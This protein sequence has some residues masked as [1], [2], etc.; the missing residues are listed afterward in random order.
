VTSDLTEEAIVA[1]LL[2][3]GLAGPH[4]SHARESNVANAGR[5]V[6]GDLDYT[7]GMPDVVSATAEVAL[8]A[9]AAV[10]GAP[11]PGAPYIDPRATIGR[12]REAAAR[13]AAACAAGARIIVA[14]GHPTGLLV[15]HQRLVRTI[16]AA[17]GTVIRPLEE[18]A[19]FREGGATRVLKYFG[20]VAALTD[21]ANVLHAHMPTA[22]EAILDAEVPD[23]VFADHGFAG[24]AV[25]R[26]IPTIAVMDT[27]DPALAVAWARGADLLIVPMDDNRSPDSY[28]VIAE[29][30]A[31]GVLGEALEP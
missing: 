11:E 19:V 12:V 5:L 15:H 24:A 14:T 2:E 4:R 17:G 18:Q 27:N 21:G 22:M 9:V 25:A 28:D 20:G 31:Q 23:L 8:A 16:T 29:L 26:G 10:T 1:R 3:G 30:F 13:L 7:F 6:T